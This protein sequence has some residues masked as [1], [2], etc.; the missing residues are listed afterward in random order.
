MTALC[1][2]YL[3]RTVTSDS[4]ITESVLLKNILHSS[5]LV[6]MCQGIIFCIEQT[7]MSKCSVWILH[8]SSFDIISD[9]KCAL[10]HIFGCLKV[11][12]SLMLK[13]TNWMHYQTFC[14][15]FFLLQLY[16]MGGVKDILVLWFV[17]IFI[18]ICLVRTINNSM[19]KKSKSHTGARPCS[20]HK[21]VGV[22]FSYSYNWHL[23]F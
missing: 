19:I 10:S 9:K 1:D 15:H 4:N 14:V 7:V 23:I 11:F 13:T 22:T 21:L 18:A 3:V 16:I 17:C 12:I 6:N 20:S 5:V 2:Q 8:A